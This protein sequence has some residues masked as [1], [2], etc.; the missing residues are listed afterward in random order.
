MI[1][2]LL[3]PI[4]GVFERSAGRTDTRLPGRKLG[5]GVMKLATIALPLHLIKILEPIGRSA[6]AN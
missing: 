1:N 5:V 4:V 2:L 6:T 3:F